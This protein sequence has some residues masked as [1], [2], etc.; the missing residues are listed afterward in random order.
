MEDW[1]ILQIF[2]VNTFFLTL[3]LV[4]RTTTSFEGI[5][6]RNLI[7]NHGHGIGIIIKHLIIICFV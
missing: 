5:Y 3:Q 6:N 4:D 7:L 1:L 2:A